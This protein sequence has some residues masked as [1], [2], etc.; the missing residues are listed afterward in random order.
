M[1]RDS[2][3]LLHII[4]FWLPGLKEAT[5]DQ[6]LLIASKRLQKS[7]LV[8][9]A[10]KEDANVD[11]LRLDL[12]TAISH[13]RGSVMDNVAPPSAFELAVSCPS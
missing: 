12:G 2:F 7:G 10:V 13:A 5:R 1:S 8:G 11:P 9:P 4:Y 3:W 6:E